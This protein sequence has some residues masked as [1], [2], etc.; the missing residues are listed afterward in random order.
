VNVGRLMVER[1]DHEAEA[2]CAVD[3]DHQVT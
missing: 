3:D 2:P 1:V